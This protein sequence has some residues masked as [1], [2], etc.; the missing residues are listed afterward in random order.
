[1]CEKVSMQANSIATLPLEEM[2]AFQTMSPHALQS[3]CPCHCG[4]ARC[5]CC[6][7]GSVRPAAVLS[8]AAPTQ[9]V[10]LMQG[11]TDVSAHDV[12]NGSREA[13]LGLL[14]RAFLH[15]QVT[16]LDCS[17]SMSPSGCA[18]AC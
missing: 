17:N 12:V 7:T 15:F 8:A 5:S 14:W 10:Q 3:S 13:T 11:S 18:A 6:S 4:Q 16:T 1:M 9:G 2:L